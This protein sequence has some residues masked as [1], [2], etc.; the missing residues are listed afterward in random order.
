MQERKVKVTESSG[1]HMKPAMEL[2][3]LASTFKSKIEIYNK[4]DRAADAK[5]IMEVTMLAAIY[6]D[7]LRIV[8]EGNDEEEAIEAM[9][10]FIANG[11]T[12]EVDAGVE[13]K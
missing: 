1:L 4:E 13:E 11:F 12:N 6:D 7:E 3:C 8:A 2:T 10:K 9:S 5:S